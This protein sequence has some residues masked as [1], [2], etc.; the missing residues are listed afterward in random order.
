MRPPDRHLV[1]RKLR[2]RSLSDVLALQSEIARTIAS[3]VEAVVT[4]AEQERLHSA[5]VNS[6]AFEAYVRGRAYLDKWTEED[7]MPWRCT[8]SSGRIELDL[9]ISPCLCRKDLIV[10]DR[11]L[12]SQP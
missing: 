3:K 9:Q 6:E 4:P 7:N 2:K 12:R 8:P 10:L 5:T 1:G 11:R